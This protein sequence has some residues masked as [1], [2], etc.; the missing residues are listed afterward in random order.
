MQLVVGTLVIPLAQLGPT[1]AITKNPVKISGDDRGR[2][3]TV[4]DNKVSNT[5][6]IVITSASESRIEFF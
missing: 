5:R 1:F 4:V 3:V 6:E 2:I